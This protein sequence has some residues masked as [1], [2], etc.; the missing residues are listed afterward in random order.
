[1]NPSDIETIEL[2]SQAAPDQVPR[3]L[4]VL[5]H[6]AG[7]AAVEMLELGRLLGDAFAESAVLLPQDLTGSASDGESLDGL[8]GRVEALAAYIRLQ[9]QRFGVL[10]SDTA[11]AGFGAGS[12]LALALGSAHDGLVGRVLAFGGGYAVWPAA[13]PAL[14]T[15]HLLHGANDNVAPVTRIRGDFAHLMELG[16]D[17]TLDVVSSAGHA[18]HPALM[19]KAVT[20]LQTCVPLRFW[21]SL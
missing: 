14:T 2:L 16:A 20:R 5:L 15:M 8:A 13:A 19:D 11:L 21:K 12:T 10:Q 18:L 9:Q 3:P 4:F 17:A 1:M 7:A 6:D